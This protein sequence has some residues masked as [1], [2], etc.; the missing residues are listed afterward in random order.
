MR[1]ESFLGVALWMAAVLA[2]PL[3][4]AL[5]GR[6]AEQHCSIIAIVV[7][8][9]LAMKLVHVGEKKCNTGSS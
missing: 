9:P 1:W 3:A 4:G 5:W 8:V 7:V 6:R 2:G